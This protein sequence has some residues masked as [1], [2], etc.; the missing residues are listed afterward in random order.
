MD[1][2]A[3]ENYERQIYDTETNYMRRPFGV[4]TNSNG[5]LNHG[6]LIVFVCALLGIFSILRQKI[7]FEH[8]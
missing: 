1:T 6:R 8:R 5:I 7:D 3:Q 2:I 4:Q